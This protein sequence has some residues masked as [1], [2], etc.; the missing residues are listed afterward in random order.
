MLKGFLL[1][2]PLVDTSQ[3][4][5]FKAFWECFISGPDI[6]LIPTDVI[7]LHSA[8]NGLF[9]WFT[10][11]WRQRMTLTWRHQE[12]EEKY[13]W[14]YRIAFLSKHFLS[15]NYSFSC[16]LDIYIASQFLSNEYDLE[17]L[18]VQLFINLLTFIF[19]DW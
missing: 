3:Y 11:W 19:M 13:N 8:V 16:P 15:I 5:S 9:M 14:Q 4:A 6:S 17:K 2:R 7:D 1:Q 10:G 12:I 18:K